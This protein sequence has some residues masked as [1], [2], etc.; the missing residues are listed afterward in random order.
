VLMSGLPP[1]D[2]RRC[3]AS[4]GCSRLLRFQAELYRAHQAPCQ[5]PA[6][7]TLDSCVEHL[8]DTVQA[9]AAWAR[10]TGFGCGT[11]Q[12]SV[13]DTVDGAE[14]LRLLAFPFAT[15]PLGVSVMMEP[16]APSSW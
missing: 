14:G 8:V 1:S 12:V 2:G 11:L 9:L 16:V 15:I 7:K 4:T 6:V 10:A 13:V 3:H 5:P